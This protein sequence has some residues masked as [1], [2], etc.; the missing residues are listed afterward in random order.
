MKIAIVTQPILENYGGLLQNYALQQVLKKMGHDPK[1]IDFWP[2][3]NFYNEFPRVFG[4]WLKTAYLR[5][6]KGVRRNFA[7]FHQPKRRNEIFDEFVSKYI[8]TTVPTSKYTCNILQQGK[9]DV[10]LVGSDQVWRPKLNLCVEDMF[11][12]FAGDFPIKRLAYAASFGIDEWEFTERQTQVCSSLAKKFESISVREISGVSLCRDRLNVDASWV[13]D[14]TLLLSKTDY[15]AVCGE[16]P[17]PQEKY[18]AAYVL[19]MNDS[20]RATC[21]SIAKERGL[22]LKTFSAD[23]QVTLTIPQWIAMFRDASYVVTDSF[24]GTVFSILFGK[25]FKCVYN[26]FR[27]AARFKSLLEMHQSGKLEEM[28]QFSLNWLKTALET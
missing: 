27:G 3:T 6:C 11:L 28:R 15:E 21:E 13:L 8:E 17:V 26:E 5:F 9:F 24:H 23:S 18:L 12:A 16:I 22:V 10:V 14:P 25:D 7:K 2:L 20:L 19:D 1:T 4:S